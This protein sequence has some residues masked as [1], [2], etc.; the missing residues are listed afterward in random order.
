MKKEHVRKTFVFRDSDYKIIEEFLLAHQD[1]EHTQASLLI[2]AI[3]E[4]K[5]KKELGYA[6]SSAP[7]SL[8][9]MFEGDKDKLLSALD[10][11]KQIYLSL[12]MT[13]AVQIEDRENQLRNLYDAK[14]ELLEAKLDTFKAEKVSLETSVQNAEANALSSQQNE[15]RALEEAEHAKQTLLD[16]REMVAKEEARNAEL[17]AENERLIQSLVE[18]DSKLSTFARFEEENKQL[19][20][21]LSDLEVQSKLDAQEIANLKR[22]N[23]RLHAVDQDYKSLQAEQNK[24]VVSEAKLA[25][26]RVSL[27]KEL[28]DMQTVKNETV[29]KQTALEKEVAKQQKKIDELYEQ[30][31]SQKQ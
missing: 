26:E 12:M 10:M 7:E 5:A 13:T 1:S 11:I 24:L 8:Q 9:S 19:S 22:E 27:Q 4:F 6:I 31:L 15:Q 28:A 29:K 30:L 18:K 16:V 17:K 25:A 21:K 2:E 3:N 23:E 20:V 14:I